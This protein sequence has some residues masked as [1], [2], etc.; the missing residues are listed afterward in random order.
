MIGRDFS[1]NERGVAAV[2]FAIT[3]PVYFLA[4]FGLAQ[5]GIWLWADFRSSARWTSPRAAR[6]S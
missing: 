5:V 3:S 1:R 2:E 4:L 6:R